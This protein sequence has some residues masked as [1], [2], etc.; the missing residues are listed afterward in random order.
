MTASSPHWARM[1]ETTFVAGI[2]FLCLVERGLGRWPFRLCLAPVVLAHW[3]GNG[4]ARRASL[5]YLRRLQSSCRPFDREPG[6]WMSLCHF[7]RFAE[8]LLD[9]L[10]ASRG[11]YPPEKVRVEREVMLAQLARGEG[12]VIVTAHIGCLEL[13]QVLADSVPDFHLTVLVHTTHAEEFNRLLLA[14]PCVSSE[15]Y[16]R[17]VQLAIVS[18]RVDLWETP[19]AR[20]AANAGR[21][22]RGMFIDRQLKEGME[23]ELEADLLGACEE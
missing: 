11:R 1:G 8:T 17:D 9:K 4:V 6:A 3:V 22:Y 7:L 5:E 20:R 16:A 15:K 14:R 19:Y 23:I 12:G 13:C 21:L 2:R 10:L 18:L